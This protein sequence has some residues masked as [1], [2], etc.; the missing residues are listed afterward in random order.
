MH[1][2]AV[3]QGV[4]IICEVVYQRWLSVKALFVGKTRIFIRNVDSQFH[5]SVQRN[6][7]ALLEE[8]NALETN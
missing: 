1:F 5:P 3:F 8:F 4:F 2:W 7:V 6:V